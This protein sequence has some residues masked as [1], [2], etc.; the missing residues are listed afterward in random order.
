MGQLPQNQGEMAAIFLDKNS[1]IEQCQSQGIKIAIAAINA[2]Q[3]TVISGEKSV[4]QQLCNHFTNAGVKVRQL[5][6]SHAFH[7]PLVEP[8]V[9][10]FKTILQETSFSQPQI[11]LVSNLTGEIADDSIMTPEYWLQHLLNTVQFH[12]GAL[13]LQSL[14]CDTFIE[15]GPQPILSGIVQSSLS[16]SEPLTLPSLRSGFSDWQVLLESLGKLYVRGAKI[17]WFS[18]D[19]DYHPRRCALPTYPFQKR[20]HW[21]SLKTPSATVP[22]ESNLVKMLSEKDKTTLMQTLLETGH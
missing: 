22:R 1:V 3:H 21:I 14:G 9:A 10:E 19:Q 15:I 4:I 8:M 20:Q 11:S 6:V 16:S 17:D 2:E 12:Q 5:K 18:F 13:F 7:S